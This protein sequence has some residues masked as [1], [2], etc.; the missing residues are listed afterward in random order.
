[1]GCEKNSYFQSESTI[2]SAIEK[3]WHRI[4]VDGGVAEDWVFKSGKIYRIQEKAGIQDTID[5]GSYTV[6]TTISDA[7][8]T[9]SGFSPTYHFNAKFTIVDIDDD[10]LVFFGNDAV[11]GGGTIYLEFTSN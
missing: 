6:N 4:R 10:V 5:T 1:M 8:I 9:L 3:R 7:F 11:N 2:N